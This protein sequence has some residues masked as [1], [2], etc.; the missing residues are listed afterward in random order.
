MNQIINDYGQF[1]FI[2]IGIACVVEGVITITTGK[3]PEREMMRLKDFSENGLRKYKILSSVMNIVGGLLC[4]AVSVIKMFNL[5]DSFIFKV[6]VIAI[7]VVMIVV[8]VIIRNSC[9]KAE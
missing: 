8:Y 1:L 9:K 6:V 5:V 2:A 4:V 3:M 7:L